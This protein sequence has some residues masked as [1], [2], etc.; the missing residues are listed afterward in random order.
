MAKPKVRQVHYER[1]EGPWSTTNREQERRKNKLFQGWTPSEWRWSDQS[2][3]SG[4]RS[5]VLRWLMSNV[6]AL[7]EGLVWKAAFICLAVYAAWCL[8][9]DFSFLFIWIPTKSAGLFLCRPL[10]RLEIWDPACFSAWDIEEL[11]TDLS[12]GFASTSHLTG[13]TI[14]RKN[15]RIRERGHV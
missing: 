15:T 2:S 10:E 1:L 11:G 8:K 14:T 9:R 12:G 6:R 4:L 5:P 13:N 7:K 3:S